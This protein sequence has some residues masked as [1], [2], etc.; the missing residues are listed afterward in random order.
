M[1]FNS[2]LQ[3]NIGLKLPFYSMILCMTWYGKCYLE[4]SVNLY[5]KFQDYDFTLVFIS[6]FIF[7]I[8]GLQINLKGCFLESLV[9]N[10][11]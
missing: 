11:N 2:F 5:Q 8:V 6:K 9:I 7:N 1:K 4:F 3:R 10:K